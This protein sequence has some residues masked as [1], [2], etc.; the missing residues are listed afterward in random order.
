MIAVTTAAGCSSDSQP[1]ATP[2]SQPGTT[3][4]TAD[5]TRVPQPSELGQR[6]GLGASWQLTTK[7]ATLRPDGLHVDIALY[8]AGAKPLAMP[9]LRKLVSVRDG[10]F[11]SDVAATAVRPAAAT[12]QPDTTTEFSLTFANVAKPKKVWVLYL[13]GSELPDSISATVVL[14]PLATT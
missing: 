12:V 11:G 3:V 6:V 8:Y 7:S 2:T 13:R 4:V 5:Q 14:R 1:K 10:L 9:D